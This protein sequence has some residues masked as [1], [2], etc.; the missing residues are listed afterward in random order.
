M[1]SSPS[2]SDGA[3]PAFSSA[4]SAQLATPTG[5]VPREETRSTA[6]TPLSVAMTAVPPPTVASSRGDD[7]NRNRRVHVH[8][9]Y[10]VLGL[11]PTATQRQITVAYHSTLLYVLDEDQKEPVDGSNHDPRDNEL[12]RHIE[13][14]YHVLSDPRKRT[15]YDRR[16]FGAERG[17]AN[18]RADDVTSVV[19]SIGSELRVQVASHLSQQLGIDVPFAYGLGVLF[20]ASLC[21]IWQLAFVVVKVENSVDWSWDTTLIPLWFWNSMVIVDI[22][23]FFASGAHRKRRRHN[24]GST[25]S[26][27]GDSVDATNSTTET[28]T[29]TGCQLWWDNAMI[30]VPILCY[31]VASFMGGRL[32]G[33]DDISEIIPC[34]IVG[35]AELLIVVSR[36][37]KALTRTD[38]DYFHFQERF[39]H[40]PK[41][42]SYILHACWFTS[43]VARFT[44]VVLCAVQSRRAH[45]MTWLSLFS[46]LLSLVV[47]S[48]F[49]SVTI[50]YLCCKYVTNP[51]WKG[52]VANA[53]FK[54]SVVTSLTSTTVM[55]AL[56]LDHRIKLQPLQAVIPVMVLFAATAIGSF[57]MLCT[58]FST[59][60]ELP[61]T[62]GTAAPYV[63]A[64]VVDDERYASSVVS[65]QLPHSRYFGAPAPYNV[66]F[67]ESE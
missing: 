29:L 13:L 6:S 60:I 3:P 30:V 51:N 44:F 54:S 48:V 40:I 9:L 12:V 36:V 32:I 53:V 43:P 65:P 17:Y 59:K 35:L 27:T 66:T 15:E 4:A 2:S 11:E 25:S 33:H 55:V 7:I 28:I 31:V 38:Y 19:S 56:A 23:I 50:Q 16:I 37:V 18:A 52:I 34:A 49:V 64:E 61:D 46:P 10:D 57:I 26:S 39:T 24:V 45:Q 42:A 62:S 1:S 47:G 14:A 21:I 20:F 67:A 63:Q 5:P 22:A 58:M 41:P 8:S